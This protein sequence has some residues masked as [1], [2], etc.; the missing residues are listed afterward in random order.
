MQ[1][2]VKAMITGRLGRDIETKQIQGGKTVSK[3]SLAHSRKVKGEKFTDWY[4][5]E[6]W[7][8]I[9]DW[10]FPLLRKG[11]GVSV[12]GD[13]AQRTYDKNDGSVGHSIDVRVSPF[14]ILLLSETNQ[15]QAQ[16]A[17]AAR[18]QPAAAQRPAAARP[19]SATP[20]EATPPAPRFPQQ[21]PRP[22]APP[23]PSQQDDDS[24]SLPF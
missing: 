22:T 15:A 13:L 8:N 23:A 19:Y 18:P 17:S 6:V 9:V 7:G 10:L 5:I 12:I 3:F 20:P 24:E 1:T 2:Q 14:D 4:N 11:V 16:P 21:P